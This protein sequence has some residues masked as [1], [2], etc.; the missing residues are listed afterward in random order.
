MGE[1]KYRVGSWGPG[2]GQ[3]TALGTRQLGNPKPEPRSLAGNQSAGDRISKSANTELP[4]ILAPV[5]LVAG[6]VW[7]TRWDPQSVP[8]T[9]EPRILPVPPPNPPPRFCLLL[10]VDQSWETHN[11]VFSLGP[12]HL[13]LEDSNCIPRG[14]QSVYRASQTAAGPGLGNVCGLWLS[15]GWASVH[16]LWLL[17]RTLASTPF[18]SLA[19]RA[20]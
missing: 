7:K 14:K 6:G 20:L 4:G 12:Q 11:K 10:R 2:G 15:R 8:C 17:G 5:W 9:K 3:A 1:D 16:D 13:M 19:I 18:P